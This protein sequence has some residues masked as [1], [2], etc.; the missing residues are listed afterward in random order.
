MLQD[1]HSSQDTPIIRS[2]LGK[3]IGAPKVYSPEQVQH[4]REELGNKLAKFWS[5]VEQAVHIREG[6]R[7]TVT[8]DMLEDGIQAAELDLHAEEVQY[9]VLYLFSWSRDIGRL[10]LNKLGRLKELGIKFDG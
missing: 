5:L 8:R 7:N 10:E 9:I 6:V 3:L 4:Y 2:I 1:L